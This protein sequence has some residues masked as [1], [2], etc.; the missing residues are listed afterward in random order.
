MVSLFKGRRGFLIL[1]TVVAIFVGIGLLVVLVVLHPLIQAMVNSFIA[2]T[3]D[4][5]QIFAVGMIELFYV[6]C[7][8]VAMIITMATGE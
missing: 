2:T 5:L 4:P 7:V 1:R 3:D 6:L 8:F